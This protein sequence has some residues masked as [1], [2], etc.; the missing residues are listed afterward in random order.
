MEDKNQT[1]R[2]LIGFHNTHTY[3]EVAE[4][5]DVLYIYL[6]QNSD[7]IEITAGAKGIKVV[8]NKVSFY[9]DDLAEF[10]SKTKGIKNANR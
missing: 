1:K 7:G 10:L 3:Y 8:M 2:Q 4:H 6:E 5:K 9:L